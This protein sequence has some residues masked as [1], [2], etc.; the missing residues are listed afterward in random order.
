M[1]MIV[2]GLVA[3]ALVGISFSAHDQKVL[4]AGFVAGLV[5]AF[6]IVPLWRWADRP[7]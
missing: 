1:L 3:W 2:A 4:A 6:V 7:D 5:V